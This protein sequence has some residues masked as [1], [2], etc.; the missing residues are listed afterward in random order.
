MTSGADYPGPGRRAR[1]PA[2]R[3]APL[4]AP[5]S[6]LCRRRYH[7]DSYSRHDVLWRGESGGRVSDGQPA[8]LFFARYRGDLR[9][10]LGD[11]RDGLDVNLINLRWP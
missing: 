10:Y 1:T 7:G 6:L 11:L 9:D 2:A 8:R 5:A 4:V 3:T